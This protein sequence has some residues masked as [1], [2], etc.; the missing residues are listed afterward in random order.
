MSSV[1]NKFFPEPQPSVGASNAD[2]QNDKKKIVA[3]I[4]AAIKYHRQG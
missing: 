4:T 1:I 2:T 3:A